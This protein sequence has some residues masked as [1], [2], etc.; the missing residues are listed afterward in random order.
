MED[1]FLERRVWDDGIGLLLRCYL[2]I[3]VVAVAAVKK[4]I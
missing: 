1:V 2:V 4:W 3:V